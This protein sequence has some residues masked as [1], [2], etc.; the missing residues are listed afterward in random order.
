MYIK[1]EQETLLDYRVYLTVTP[2]DYA[3]AYQK[4]LATYRREANYPGFRKGQ[5]PLGL[6]KRS[7]GQRVLNDSL[8]QVVSNAMDEYVSEQGWDMIA[9]P[10]QEDIPTLGEQ[11]GLTVMPEYN[12][13]FFIGLRPEFSTDMRSGCYDLYK[14]IPSEEQVQ[15]HITALQRRFFENPYP[16]TSAPGD[17]LMIRVARIDKSPAGLTIPPFTAFSIDIDTIPDERLRAEL[18][19]IGE[20]YSTRT[21]LAQ[22]LHVPLSDW[23]QLMRVGPDKI[24][25][26][27]EELR[28]E[29][30]Y[31]IR[32]G[33]AELGPEL[34]AK[35]FEADPPADQGEFEDRIRIIQTEQIGE[36]SENFLRARLVRDYLD[37]VDFDLPLAYL[38]RLYQSTQ[39]GKANG[40]PDESFQAF[41]N[42]FRSDLKTRAALEEAD[43]DITDDEVKLEA[44]RHVSGVFAQSGVQQDRSAVFEY[45]DKFLQNKDNRFRMEETAR[46][47]KLGYLLRSRVEVKEVEVSDEEYRRLIKTFNEQ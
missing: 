41:V 30:R 7:V 37:A 23:P 31:V 34:Y 6:I 43:W 3:D 12:Y 25:P 42:W 33:L 11:D 19:G 32:E 47:V 26:A 1:H 2:S 36:S 8:K 13:I 14:V 22:L 4:E 44:I 35:A 15:Q 18:T 40:E 46:R 45:A 20:G 21:S 28:V 39:E 17:R 38:S 24:P 9:H 27:D 10:V 29:V 16:E 5:A